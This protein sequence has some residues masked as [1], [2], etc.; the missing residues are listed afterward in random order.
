MLDHNIFPFYS[1]SLNLRMCYCFIVTCMIHLS[2][3]FFFCL[4]VLIHEFL[5]PDRVTFNTYYMWCCSYIDTQW[6]LGNFYH[7][8]LSGKNFVWL[9]FFTLVCLYAYSILS[10]CIFTCPRCLNLDQCLWVVNI[11][12]WLTVWTWFV[13]VNKLFPCVSVCISGPAD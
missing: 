3:S 9:Y 12:I 1:F 11:R 2:T 10:L 13:S 5:P 4:S 6:H 8:I 7:F